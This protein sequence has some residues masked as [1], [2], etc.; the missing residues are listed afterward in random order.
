[1]KKLIASNVLLLSS[2][3]Y[4]LWSISKNPLYLSDISMEVQNPVSVS[5][6]NIQI[7]TGII[8]KSAKSIYNVSLIPIYLLVV[9]ALVL[10]LLSLKNR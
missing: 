5:W 10:I 6:F 7:D 9:V 8:E 1:M 4:T 2:L 3:L